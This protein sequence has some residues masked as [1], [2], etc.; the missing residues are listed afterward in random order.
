M[1]AVFVLFH[2]GDGTEQV[3]VFGLSDYEI[4]HLSSRSQASKFLFVGLQSV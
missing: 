2:S 4:L 3:M 1:F